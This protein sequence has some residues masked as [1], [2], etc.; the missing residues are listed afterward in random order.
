M[1]VNLINLVVLTLNNL[2]LFR[3]EQEH[4]QLNLIYSEILP[5]PETF[6]EVKLANFYLGIFLGW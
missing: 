1:L 3:Q 5:F 6:F 4:F 2:E